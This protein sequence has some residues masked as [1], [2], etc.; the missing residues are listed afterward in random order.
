MVHTLVQPG[1]WWRGRLLR[2][3]GLDKKVLSGTLNALVNRFHV[4]KR[5]YSG[6]GKRIF[7]ELDNEAALANLQF[8]PQTGGPVVSL[9]LPTEVGDALFAYAKRVNTATDT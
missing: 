6:M 4:V 3:T 8:D 7:Y 1:D 5:K 2:E 9:Q